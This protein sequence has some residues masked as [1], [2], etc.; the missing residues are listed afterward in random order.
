MGTHFLVDLQGPFLV[1]ANLMTV[2]AEHEDFV[3]GVVVNFP[4]AGPHEEMTVF[5]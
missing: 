2:T 1:E 4:G 3:D 5:T